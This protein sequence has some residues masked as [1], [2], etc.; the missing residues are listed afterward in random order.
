VDNAVDKYFDPA[1]DL[2]VQY[3]VSLAREQPRIKLSKLFDKTFLAMNR[4]MWQELLTLAD[5]QRRV[6][7]RTRHLLRVIVFYLFENRGIE[8][9]FYLKYISSVDRIIH[10]AFEDD[11]KRLRRFNTHLGQQL[12]LYRDAGEYNAT[13][14]EGFYK[15]PESFDVATKIIR[16][17]TE[18]ARSKTDTTLPAIWF[19]N[20]TDKGVDDQALFRFFKQAGMPA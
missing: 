1:L 12:S 8:R 4:E 17:T 18:K 20:L 6:V 13:D 2:C 9:E 14:W 7:F 16:E 19:T 15:D 3:H 11:P 5:I 10:F